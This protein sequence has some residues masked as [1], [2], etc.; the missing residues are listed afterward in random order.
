[1]NTYTLVYIYKYNKKYYAL[2]IILFNIP[3]ISY[4]EM[5]ILVLLNW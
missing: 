1:M 3:R 5:T 2:Q 4:I